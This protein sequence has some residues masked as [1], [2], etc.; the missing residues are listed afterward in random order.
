MRRG[1]A[2]EPERSPARRRAAAVGLAFVLAYLALAAI[3]GHLSPL[4]RRPLLDGTAGPVAYN[5]VTPPPELA[6]TNVPPSAGDFTLAL[7]ER[8]SRPDVLT[9]DDGQLTLILVAGTI[10]PAQGQRSVHLTAE[11]LDPSSFGPPPAPLDIVGNVYRLRATYEPG[12]HPVTSVDKPIETILV[13]PLPPNAHAT[14]HS[15]I[16]SADG[17]SWSVSKGTDSPGNQ[18]AE[19]PV[20]SFG[21]VAVGGD[22]QPGAASP[23]PSTSGGSSALGITLIVLAV[24]A[25]L[26]GVGL[27]LRGR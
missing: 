10:P 5:W 23:A 24:C 27:L 1:P 7:T 14:S 17:D 16:S 21:D 12:G 4:A 13:Y 3:S 9:T 15:V 26:V 22:L 11:P 8:G 19:G 20:A 18:Q 2:P 25:A 6:G